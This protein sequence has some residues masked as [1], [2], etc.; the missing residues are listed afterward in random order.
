MVAPCKQ[1]IADA[2]VDK[3]DEVI[4]VGGTTRIPSVQ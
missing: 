4:L 3:I 2:D 1:C